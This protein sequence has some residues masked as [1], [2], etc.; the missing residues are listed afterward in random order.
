MHR[1]RVGALFIDHPASSFDAGLKFWAAA[2]GREPNAERQTHSPYA[3]LDYTH[4]DL[5]VELQR[6]GEGTPP[7]VHL[8]L[9]T[10]DVE[11]EV[12]RLE[13]LGAK[14][15]EQHGDYWQMVDPGGSSSASSRHTPRTSRNRPR[16]GT[17]R[18]GRTA[19]SPGSAIRGSLWAPAVATPPRHEAPMPGLRRHACSCICTTAD[20]ERG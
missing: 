13:A 5:L 16:S 1:S 20:R 14:R 15:L 11:A 17:D 18:A 12:Q 10:D 2:T 19:R 3:S 7:R 4:G 8:D 9:D 6:T